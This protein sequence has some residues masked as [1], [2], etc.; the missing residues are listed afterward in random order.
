[1]SRTIPAGSTQRNREGEPPPAVGNVGVAQTCSHE[2]VLTERCSDIVPRDAGPSVASG[3]TKRYG[4]T[5]ALRDLD[6]DV[7]EGEVLA[8]SVKWCRKDHDDSFAAR[9]IRPTSARRSCSGCTL[10]ATPS[11]ST[12]ASRTCPATAALWPSLTG[13]ETLHF[14]AEVHG[15][16]DDVYRKELIERSTSI[17]RKKARAYSKGNRQKIALIAG[18]RSPRTSCSSARRA[19]PVASTP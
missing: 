2:D 19:D 17:R 18:V 5:N 7:Q 13:E 1:V 11:R 12:S 10:S 6:L 3:L 8:F 9:L 14:F 15:S 16:V 4:A